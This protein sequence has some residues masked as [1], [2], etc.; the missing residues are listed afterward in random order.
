MAVDQP[1]Q[2]EPEDPHVGSEDD[3]PRALSPGDEPPVVPPVPYEPG[4]E[5]DLP[6]RTPTLGDRIRSAS[7]PLA[8][9]AFF[10]LGFTT[11]KW[12][13]VWVVFLVPAVLDAWFKPHKKS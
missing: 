1:S 12:W 8:V 7:A 10:V 3:P 11:G 4:G 13:I 6:T 5:V 9:L 2:P